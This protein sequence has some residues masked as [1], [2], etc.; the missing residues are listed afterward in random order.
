MVHVYMVYTERAE[1]ASVSR[2]TSHITTK[3]RCKYTTS[4]DI[5]TCYKKRQSL[6]HDHTAYNTSV[7]IKTRY[8]MLVAYLEP[9]ATK[10]Q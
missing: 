7:D 4:V 5:K 3:Q 8:K 10:A 9:H 6:I 2:G 1:T